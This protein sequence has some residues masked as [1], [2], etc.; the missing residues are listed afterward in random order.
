MR[1]LSLAIALL[2]LVACKPLTRAPVADLT[3]VTDGV[4]T[5]GMVPV[6]KDNGTQAYRLLVCRQSE[7]YP[8]WMLADS[9]RCRPA[10]LDQ[11]NHEVVF[12]Q[13]DTERDFATKYMGYGKAYGMP[14][15]IAVSSAAAALFGVGPWLMKRGFV[16]SAMKHLSSLKKLS[17]NWVTAIRARYGFLYAE[18]KTGKLA[19]RLP[20][21]SID[22]KSALREQAQILTLAEELHRLQSKKKLLLNM[23]KVKPDK[24]KDV[25]AQLTKDTEKLN[26][27]IPAPPLGR[28]KYIDGNVDADIVKL[29]KAAKGGDLDAQRKYFDK[30][31]KY[32]E[33]VNNMSVINSYSN[34]PVKDFSFIDARLQDAEEAITNTEQLLRVAKNNRQYTSIGVKYSS[35]STG[36]AV[37][38][39]GGAA[40]ALATMTSL[41]KSVWGYADRQTNA[42]WSQIFYED[43]SDAHAVKDLSAVLTALADLFGHKVNEHALAL[44]N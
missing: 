1:S 2:L 40:F 42:H 21:I 8:K 10:L 11:D 43:I 22:A 25:I 26:G 41:D 36:A 12:L 34:N 23:E 16:K 30:L 3:A 28:G 20:G 18:H 5:L 44:G 17:P 14:T 24:Q 19:S 6:E 7:S 39:T 38:G 27:G 13:D 15:L 37:L 32:N 33:I 31:P 35:V 29:E 9:N 4:L